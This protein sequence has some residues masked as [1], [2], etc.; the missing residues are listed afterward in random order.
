MLSFFCTFFAGVP[1]AFSMCP[2]SGYPACTAHRAI[3]VLIQPPPN[4]S[5]SHMAL[6]LVLSGQ[7]AF[8]PHPLG[9][10]VAEQG[11]QSG[12]KYQTCLI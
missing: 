12:V 6:C 1:Y 5:L 11:H 2:R 9:P 8:G 4:K 3:Y 10:S 7:Q